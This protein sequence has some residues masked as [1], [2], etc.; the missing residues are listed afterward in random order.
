MGEVKVK[1]TD[2]TEM[3]FR[4]AAMEKFGYAK[5]SL[6]LAAEEAIREWATRQKN[7][8]KVIKR[9]EPPTA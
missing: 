8:V 3:A 4:K 7:K 9:I 2:D 5:G 1:L 6:S